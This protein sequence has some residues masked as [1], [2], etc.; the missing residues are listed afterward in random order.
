MIRITQNGDEC[1]SYFEV[2]L[3]IE[4]QYKNIVSTDGKFTGSINTIVI[5]C[6]PS[7]LKEMLSLVRG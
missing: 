1:T 4:M 5:C 6:L 3:T 7:L 2:S